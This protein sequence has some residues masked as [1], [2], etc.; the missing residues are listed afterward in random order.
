M[1]TVYYL[2][3]KATLGGFK[4]RPLGGMRDLLLVPP[5]NSILPSGWEDFVMLHAPHANLSMPMTWYKSDGTYRCKHCGA[6]VNVNDDLL[7]R[8][9]QSLSNES[10]EKIVDEV[11][12]GQIMFAHSVKEFPTG[13]QIPADGI[14]AKRCEDAGFTK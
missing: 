7:R 10:F 9:L 2:I 6:S 12:S 13:V 8:V 11:G 3:K 1:T 4:A 14:Y 5:I